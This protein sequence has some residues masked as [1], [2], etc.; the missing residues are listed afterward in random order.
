MDL[1]RV[2]WG[3]HPI[4]NTSVTPLWGSDTLSPFSWTTWSKWGILQGTVGPHSQ[5]T[6]WDATTP[7][8]ESHTGSRNCHVVCKNEYWYLLIADPS[9]L[10]WNVHLPPLLRVFTSPLRYKSQRSF[11]HLI[12]DT[13]NFEQ[14]NHSLSTLFLIYCLCQNLD[15]WASTVNSFPW[16]SLLW[17]S[18]A[19]FASQ[20]WNSDISFSLHSF[21][22]N[23]NPS[24]WLNKGKIVYT[25]YRR[26]KH[27]NILKYYLTTYA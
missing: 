13:I 21:N 12:A 23:A 14:E 11:H 2:V 5:T 18:R 17:A 24:L 27:S 10:T 6:D 16:K 19:Y 26:E 3:H 8:L 9:R 22:N 20:K 15:S 4:Y 7:W 1:T 25:K